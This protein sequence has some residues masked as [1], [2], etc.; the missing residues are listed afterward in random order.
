MWRVSGARE[1]TWMEVRAAVVTARWMG[2]IGR[3]KH[4]T[5]P[6]ASAGLEHVKSVNVVSFCGQTRPQ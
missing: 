2:K 1:D 5:Q 6:I 4:K 3:H